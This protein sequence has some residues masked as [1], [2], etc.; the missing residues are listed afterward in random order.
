MWSGLETCT[1]F[2]DGFEHSLKYVIVDND[3]EQA[4]AVEVAIKNERKDG[5]EKKYLN[6]C[7]DI[8]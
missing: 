6:G 2:S 3:M 8:L 1:I 4:N 5:T 7:T